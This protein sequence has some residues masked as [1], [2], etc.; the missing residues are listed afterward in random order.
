MEQNLD[1]KLHKDVSKLDVD[2]NSLHL[3]SELIGSENIEDFDNKKIVFNFENYNQGDCEIYNLQKQ[4]AKKLTNRL[5]NMS[6]VLAKHILTFQ[7]SGFVC[8]TVENAKSYS[9][10]FST[11]PPD[12]E[13]LEV[14]YSDKG[15]LFGYMVNNIF[16]V[17][18]VLIKHR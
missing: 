2:K 4:D 12:V 11:L 9:S 16:S 7:T 6:S 13:L 14:Y 15:R 5:Q 8:K 3:T 10:L 1:P 18:A 17:V